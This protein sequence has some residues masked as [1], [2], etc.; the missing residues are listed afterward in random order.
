[1]DGSIEVQIGSKESFAIQVFTEHC[2][3]GLGSAYQILPYC[4]VSIYGGRRMDK[5]PYGAKTISE[6]TYFFPTVRVS[7]C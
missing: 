3:L 7:C 6:Q 4:A 2:P 5:L 1:M